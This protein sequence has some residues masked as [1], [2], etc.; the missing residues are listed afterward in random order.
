MQEFSTEQDMVATG[1]AAMGEITIPKLEGRAALS[2]PAKRY[3]MF[4]IKHENYAY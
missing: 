2:F 4:L 1:F 3:G